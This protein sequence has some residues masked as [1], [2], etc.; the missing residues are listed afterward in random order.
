M[1]WFN[2][3]CGCKMF[4]TPIIHVPVDCLW[5]TATTAHDLGIQK[6][7]TVGAACHY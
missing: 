1:F 3:C 2:A 4:T 7:L 5:I 6:E